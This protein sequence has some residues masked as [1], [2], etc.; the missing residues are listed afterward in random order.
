LVLVLYHLQ[1]DQIQNTMSFKLGTKKIL[2]G[3]ALTDW[4]FVCFGAVL[5]LSFY[6]FFR[7]EVIFITA[8]FKVTDENILYAKTTPNNEFTTSFMV[9]DTERDELGRVV[10]EIIGV[11]SYKTVPEQHVVY[12]DIKLKSVYNPRKKQYS[13][14]G[15]NI[16]FGE[17]FTF[18]FTKVRF[19][20]LVVDFPGFRDP[21]GIKF[22]KTIVK[23]QLR[24]DS[25]G[26]SDVY[27]VPNFV[28]AAVKKGDIV[29]DSKDNVLIKILDVSIQSA[30][31]LVVSS[32]G[33]PFLVDDPYLKDVYYTIEL[34]TKEVDGKTYM[35]DYIPVLINTAVPINMNTVSI[36][37]TITEI[38]Q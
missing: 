13:V 33:Q 17:S 16:I 27:G 19:K 29:T 8:R 30:K 11:E 36:W 22:K 24:Y 6:L 4:I 31:R 7:R 20:A 21:Q 12:L 34:A 5:L 14:R 25:R 26:F 32:S 3:L 23:T 37:P 35:F 9:G 28:A 1:R 10:S 18:S 2:G 15:K 38:I